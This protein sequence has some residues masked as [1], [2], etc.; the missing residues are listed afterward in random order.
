MP[1]TYLPRRLVLRVLLAFF[2][3]FQ[4]GYTTASAKALDLKHIRLVVPLPA[5]SAPDVLARHLAESMSQSLGLTVVVENKTGFSGFIGGQ[6]VLRA[7]AD[8]SALYVSVSS[9]VVITPQTYRTIPYHPVHDLKPLVQLGTTSL[10]LAVSATG[11]FA[12]LDDYLTAAREN[13]GTVSF[14][15]FGTGTSAHLIGEALMRAADVKLL[16][17]PYKSSAS[18]DVIGGH[19]DATITDVGSLQPYLADPARMRVLGVIGTATRDP[20]LPDAPTFGEQGY[21]ALDKMGGWLGVFASKGIEPE[22][23]KILSAAIVEAAQADSFK[24][25]MATL[26]YHHTGRTGAAF[27]QIVQ[28]DYQRWGD[29][30][31][32]I[33]GIQLN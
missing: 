21:P 2:V 31:Q 22:V 12:K 28:D 20:L 30:I 1:L 9:F 19:V 32:A 23:A 3:L 4:V 29:T 24:Q 10:A 17:V 6:D 7:P 5:G 16:H 8:G 26:G 15:S 11:R 14:A 25:A 13:P 18:P 33:G 27:E